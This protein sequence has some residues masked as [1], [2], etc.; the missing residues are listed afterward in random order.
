[1]RRRFLLLAAVCA[2]ALWLLV[3]TQAVAS[4]VPTDVTI[5]T[6]RANADTWSAT[7]AITDSGTFVDPTAFFGGPATFHAHRT[8]T[9]NDGTFNVTGNVRILPSSDPDVGF[10]VV[11]RWAI[12]SGTGAYANAHGGGVI[13]EALVNAGLVGTWT[14]QITFAP[15]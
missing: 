14:G 9:G 11:G 15:N 10:Y 2:V 5:H 4:S 8:F 6:L 1:M 7:G 13:N 12:T 3:P